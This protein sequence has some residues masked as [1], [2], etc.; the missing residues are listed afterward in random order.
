MRTCWGPH[1]HVELKDAFAAQ[2]EARVMHIE[3]KDAFAAQVEARVMHVE[4]LM[5]L[6]LK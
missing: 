6:R 1:A 4:L 3:L 2:V 5:I